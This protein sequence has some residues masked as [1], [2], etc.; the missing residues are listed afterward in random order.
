MKD[1][2]ELIE[3][4][5]TSIEKFEKEVKCSKVDIKNHLENLR[6]TLEYVAQEFNQSLSNP[7]S[8]VYFPYAFSKDE[9][10]F[11]DSIKKNFPTLSSEKPDLFNLLES[12]QNYKANDD[13][14]YD[15]CN[16]TNEAKH[17]KL[18]K[19]IETETKGI[20]IPGLILSTN[21]E[22]NIGNLVIGDVSFKNFR[23][24]DDKISY[25]SSEAELLFEVINEKTIKFQDNEYDVIDFLK[26][27]TNNVELFIEKYKKL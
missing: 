12:I 6:S 15:L 1:Y 20:L 9:A 7:K 13:W 19:T 10:S 8:K 4:C 3:H 17:K 2:E 26:K 5:K 11:L 23:I 27:C 21:S 24:K 18:L 22:V 14:L 25:E 16:L